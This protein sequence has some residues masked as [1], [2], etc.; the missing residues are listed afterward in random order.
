MSFVFTV[1]CVGYDVSNAPDPVAV[2]LMI[3]AE[4]IQQ[5]SSYFIKGPPF[6]GP[7]VEDVIGFSFSGVLL[8]A[9]PS[10]LSTPLFPCKI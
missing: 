2:T 10:D 7:L 5:S 8:E 3:G 1:S 6:E 4:I 9:L